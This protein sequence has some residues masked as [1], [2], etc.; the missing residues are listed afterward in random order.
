M[1]AKKQTNDAP[2]SEKA[3]SK[4]TRKGVPSRLS[5]LTGLANVTGLGRKSRKTVQSASEKA[6]SGQQ[7]TAAGE[8]MTSV[9]TDPVVATEKRVTKRR[10][11]G[12]A[13]RVRKRSKASNAAT[14]E[15]A[16]TLDPASQGDL[17]EDASSSPAV[18]LRKK[19]SQTKKASRSTG[20]EGA[21]KLKPAKDAPSTKS[22][23]QGAQL[24]EVE[25]SV[26]VLDENKLNDALLKVVQGNALEAPSNVVFQDNRLINANYKL[27]INHKRLIVAAIAKAGNQPITDERFYRLTRKDLIAIG[28]PPGSVRTVMREAFEGS[29]YNS[30]VDVEFPPTV[31]GGQNIIMRMRWVQSVVYDPNHDCVDI[32]FGRHMA[33]LISGLSREYTTYQISTVGSLK[34][35]NAIRIFEML[36]QYKNGER[37]VIAISTLLQ[38]LQ[39]ESNFSPSELRKRILD[40]AIKQINEHTMMTVSYSLKAVHGRRLDT[41]I[42]LWYS[43]E[44]ASHENSEQVVV[45]LTRKQA[46]HFGMILHARADFR[47]EWG[48][49][50]LE[51][52]DSLLSELIDALQ[53]PV[54]TAY[55]LPWLKKCGFDPDFAKNK[56]RSRRKKDDQDDKL[57]TPVLDN[58]DIDPSDL[59][60]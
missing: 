17:F 12:T 14:A 28:V 32:C 58:F 22:V 42:F 33:K 23:T 39:V 38:R 24:F 21:L 19:S 45:H 18:K 57:A 51:S 20:S 53:D 40:P 47:S 10:A 11:F 36:S 43:G 29:L 13:P 55:F 41:I 2:T 48:R 16:A 27:P 35:F 37:L 54:Q 31:P 25:N 15:A 52:W 3:P 50:R 7:P 44:D 46:T 59:A 4:R 30:S 49:G 34:S 8:D 5:L 56:S 60:S 26:S 1:T 6:V 9:V